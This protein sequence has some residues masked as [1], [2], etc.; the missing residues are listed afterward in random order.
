MLKKRFMVVL[1]VAFCLALT[2]GGGAWAASFSDVQ[3]HWAE[4]IIDE[5]SSLGMINGYPDGT[6]K[7]NRQVTRAEFVTLINRAFCIEESNTDPGFTD[8]RSSNWYYEDVAVAKAAGYIEG[9]PDNLFK[10]NNGISRQEVAAILARLLNLDETTDELDKLTDKDSIADWARGYVGANVDNG[11]FI[12]M[13]NGAFQPARGITRAETLAVLDRALDDRVPGDCDGDGSSDGRSES[14]DEI[15]NDDDNSGIEGTVIYNG[16]PVE[17]ATVKVYKANSNNVLETEYTNEDGEFE[18]KLAPGK[19]DITASSSNRKTSKNDIEVEESKYTNVELKLT[20]TSSG[21]GGSYSTTPKLTAATI[22]INPQGD[23]NDNITI[24]VTLN[25]DG[26]K[27]TI[28]L[29]EYGDY[30]YV[31]GG[32]VTCS[33][34]AE[35]K[36]TGI[37]GDYGDMLNLVQSKLQIQTLAAGKEEKLDLLKYLDELDPQDD[38]ISMWYLRT[39]LGKQATIKGTLAGNSRTVD[40]NLTVILD[41]AV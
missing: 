32:T 19:Y 18:F 21:G 39:L 8:V 10:P 9:Y 5:W 33:E 24:P 28:D 17:N 34:V 15:I 26:L 30:D 31:I 37:N 12:G 41:K 3:G 29:S 4:D 14:S 6:F 40:V 13:P 25:S 20:R 27:G 36:V 16:E 1:V 35:L 2:A 38:G 22:T 11:V 23:N 7:P